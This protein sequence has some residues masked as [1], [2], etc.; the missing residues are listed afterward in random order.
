MTC[1]LANCSQFLLELLKFRRT[2]GR[3]VERALFELL[4]HL[5]DTRAAAGSAGD[6]RCCEGRLRVLL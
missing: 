1:S 6:S 2:A 4:V 5:G 3:D